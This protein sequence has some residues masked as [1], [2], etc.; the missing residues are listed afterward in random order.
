MNRIFLQQ[1]ESV[2]TQLVTQN[3]RAGGAQRASPALTC[4]DGRRD[5]R[6][7]TCDPLTLRT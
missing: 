3:T 4:N 6:I 7:R 5:D 2:A 1:A